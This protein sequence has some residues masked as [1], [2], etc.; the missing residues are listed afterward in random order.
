MAELSFVAV[1]YSIPPFLDMLYASQTNIITQANITGYNLSRNLYWISALL[2][3][4][5]LRRSS[6]LLTR[7]AALSEC[8]GA[9][10]GRLRE[11]SLNVCND[12][13]RSFGMVVWY[14]QKKSTFLFFS[15]IH[16]GTVVAAFLFLCAFVVYVIFQRV[17]PPALS[18]RR[19]CFLSSADMVL[20]CM[21]LMSSASLI[22]L[23]AERAEQQIV[24]SVNLIGVFATVCGISVILLL[25]ISLSPSF[26]G[27]HEKLWVFRRA[28]FA[29]SG[30]F[31]LCFGILGLYIGIQAA[32][33][34]SSCA[35][36]ACSAIECRVDLVSSSII[37][38]IC[39][40]VIGTSGLAISI[41]GPLVCFF[42]Q[43]AELR[44]YTGDIE[45]DF[46]LQ[47]I[48]LEKIK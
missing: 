10:M 21:S 4:I 31:G 47:K 40:F 43:C 26:F 14:G 29:F 12:A 48:N 28:V 45:K 35:I 34:A 7:F 44:P 19:H 3:E 22:G 5:A 33:V 8:D 39:G 16:R 27:G 32:L 46:R 41:Y 30:L 6:V 2:A 37:N 38:A 13:K 24:G 25:M 23:I 18:R 20:I 42:Q 9:L 1:N 11:L 15:S 17:L 36:R